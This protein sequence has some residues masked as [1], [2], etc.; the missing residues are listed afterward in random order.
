MKTVLYGGE[1]AD[2]GRILMKSWRVCGVDG[3]LKADS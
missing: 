1:R 3:K 2:D